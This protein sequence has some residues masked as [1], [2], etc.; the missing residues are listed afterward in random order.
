MWDGCA[1]VM[2]VVARVRHMHRYLTFIDIEDIDGCN[3]R[4]LGL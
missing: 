1:C 3:V 4:G 2:G